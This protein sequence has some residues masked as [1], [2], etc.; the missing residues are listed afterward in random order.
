[1]GGK[2][3]KGSWVGQLIHESWV[4]KLVRLFIHILCTVMCVCVLHG[5]HCV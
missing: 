3:E 1:M 4:T 2:I 5:M